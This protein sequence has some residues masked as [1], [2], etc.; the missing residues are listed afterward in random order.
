MAGSSGRFRCPTRS[1]LRSALPISVTACFPFICRN[2]RRPRTRRRSRSTWK[3]AIEIG[4][5]RKGRFGGPFFCA[6]VLAF[7]RLLE[8]RPVEN[9]HL[10]QFPKTDQASRPKRGE[11]AANGF[12]REAEIVGDVPSAHRQ[13]HNVDPMST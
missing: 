13:V 5:L 3:L 2:S 12:L 10:A 4:R 1:T 7:C 9:L 11:D 8:N 6:G